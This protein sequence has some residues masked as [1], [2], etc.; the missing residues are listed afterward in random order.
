[1]HPRCAAL[2]RADRRRPGDA[3]VVNYI[4]AREARCPRS[5]FR[6][7][8]RRAAAR[9]RRCAARDD[10]GDPAPGR[11]P[12]RRRRRACGRWLTTAARDPWT[13]RGRAGQQRGALRAPPAAARPSQP[14]GC[15][16]ARPVLGGRRGPAG[17][18]WPGGGDSG[19]RCP[20]RP[21]AVPGRGRDVL[22]LQL[23]VAD[24]AESTAHDALARGFPPCPTRAP[25]G[26]TPRPTRQ[27]PGSR[28][29][30]LARW[31]NAC[32]TVLVG[33]YHR[34]DRP[35]AA[36]F[37][38]PDTLSLAEAGLPRHERPRCGSGD[39]GTLF[40]MQV[41]TSRFLFVTHVAGFIATSSGE[42]S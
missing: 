29:R 37:A 11:L 1:M 20:R 6:G 16:G 4:R 7:R 23:G 8:A 34:A 15:V 17:A 33:P 30:R 32:C 41:V 2:R 9:E 25:P 22:E 19:A 21:T 39:I 24:P 36:P 10:R 18:R 35:S 28:A 31:R 26:G 5:A 12:G 3:I 40:D 14:T 13:R 38:P 42:G 27:R